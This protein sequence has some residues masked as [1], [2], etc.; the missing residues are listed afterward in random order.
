MD[1]VSIVMFDGLLNVCVMMKWQS[2]AASCT[3]SVSVSLKVCQTD[4]GG[5]GG[6]VWSGQVALLQ[7]PYHV[8]LV[9]RLLPVVQFFLQET[10][11]LAE[12]LLQH[13]VVKANAVSA[14]N[15]T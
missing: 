1:Q 6:V 3:N 15:T 11:L 2:S 12:Q 7:A 8:C 5:S 10:L 14:T 4:E 13:K 9:Q